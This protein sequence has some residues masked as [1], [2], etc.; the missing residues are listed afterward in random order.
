[1]ADENN[2]PWQ[3]KTYV[4]GGT[5]GAAFHTTR[6]GIKTA[7]I[8]APIRNLHSP[9]NVGKISDMEAV[10]KLTWL[11]LEYLRANIVS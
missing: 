1:L 5:D 2:I 10:Y 3:T 9:A 8:A 4:A 6:S 11:F 7:G